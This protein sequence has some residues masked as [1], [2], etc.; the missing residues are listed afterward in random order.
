MSNQSRDRKISQFNT[1][2]PL[3]SGSYVSYI[4]NGQNYKIAYADFVSGIGVTGTIAQ[5]GDPTAVPVLSVSGSVNNI[6]NIEPGAGIY[7]AVS[8]FGGVAITHNFTGDVTGVPV[9]TGTTDASPVVR[10]LVAGSGIGVSASGDQIVISTSGTPVSTKTIQVNS[11]ADLP[12]AVAGVRTLLADTEYLL[13]NDINLGTDRLV[14]ASTTVISGTESILITLTYTGTGDMLTMSDTSNR[15][16]NLT[17]NCPNGR[18]F[19][20]SCTSRQILRCNDV[21]I[22]E[23]DQIGLF[24]GVDAILRFTNVSPAL[25]NTNGASFTGSFR[26]V[27][28]EVSAAVVGNGNLF[29]LGVATFDSFTADTI[30]ADVAAGSYVIDGAASSANINAGGNGIVSRVQISGLGGTVNGVSVDDALWS[31]YGNNDEP[32]T[33][34]DGLLSMQ[35]NATNTVISAIN[36][37]VLVAGTWTVVTTSQFTGT[38]A[39]RL[40]YNG[41]KNAKLPITIS[42]TMEPVSGTNINMSAYAVIDGVVIANSKKTAAASAGAPASITIPWQE[43]F[44][45]ATYVEVFVENN[46]TTSD[47]LVSSAI[48]RC[49]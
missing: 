28:W 6:R 34:P 44:S 32:D 27:L 12:A 35:G 1:L 42:L 19:N 16:A 2:S 23:V 8:A 41:G 7:A 33:R 30:A 36:T 40:T 24:N 43:I 29:N 25:I 45:T 11:T 4:Y 38:A 22:S 31:F 39:G 47:I 20:W 14:L 9:L 18:I 49:N 48:S 21:T 5:L 17:I 3:P 13:T 37:P 46:D 15:I 10:S 26:T